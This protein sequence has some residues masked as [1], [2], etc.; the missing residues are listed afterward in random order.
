MLSAIYRH[1]EN[2]MPKVTLAKYLRRLLLFIAVLLVHY[3]V[4]FIPAAEFFLLYVL[5]FKP[6]WFDDF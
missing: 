3:L 5:F 1:M 2:A 6:K 4:V